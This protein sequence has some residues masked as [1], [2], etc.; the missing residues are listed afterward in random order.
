VTAKLTGSKVL[1]V[2]DETMVSLMIESMLEDIGAQVVGPAATVDQALALLNMNDVDAVL[3]DVN[4][5]EG[6]TSKAIADRLMRDGIPFAFVTGYGRGSI[7]EA[8]ET[9]PIVPKPFETLKL[10]EV[11]VSLMTPKNF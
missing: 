9:V 7:S 6:G 4:L 8:Y 3:L 1:V 2:E 5:G 11:L 10:E